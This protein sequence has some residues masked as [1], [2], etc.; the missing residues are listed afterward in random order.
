MKIKTIVY[1]TN[2]NQTI[3][4]LPSSVMEKYSINGKLDFRIK[5]QTFSSNIIKDTRLNKD[6]S[7]NTRGI[8]TIPKNVSDTLR[9]INK[10]QIELIIKSI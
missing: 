2:N 5:S 8:I 3:T 4:S 9:L 7:T 1:R 6:G 10:Q